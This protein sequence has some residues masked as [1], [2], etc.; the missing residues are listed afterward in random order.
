MKYT[1]AK[2]IQKMDVIEF[3]HDGEIILGTVVGGPT[4]MEVMFIPAKLVFAIAT[5]KTIMFIDHLQVFRKFE[6]GNVDDLSSLYL[7]GEG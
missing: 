4:E 1:E 3:R 2:N 5:N 7:S 6:K